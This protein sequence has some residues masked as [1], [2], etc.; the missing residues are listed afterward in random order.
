[1]HCVWNELLLNRRV[2]LRLQ[3]PN[4]VQ[5]L[6]QHL[7]QM[8]AQMADLRAKTQ[9]A[10]VIARGSSKTAQRLEA[11]L[12]T[13]VVLQLP[14]TA[15]N[16]VI[17]RHFKQC[18]TITGITIARDMAGK[19]LGHASIE[20]QTQ[21]AVSKAVW[22]KNLHFMGAKIDIVEKQN[23]DDMHPAP[24]GAAD[25]GSLQRE[26][27]M[28]EGSEA[29]SRQGAAAGFGGPRRPMSWKRPGVEGFQIETAVA[30]GASP[31]MGLGRKASQLVWKRPDGMSGPAP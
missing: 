22:M 30:A 12:R 17:E 13:A 11:D 3:V 27:S 29:G 8:E 14:P 15:T 4:D 18:G 24:A 16:A 5:A 6:K 26:V 28:E 23:Y 10:A 7:Q 21:Q 31:G 19:P 20:F 9:Q 1:M 25:P 2:L